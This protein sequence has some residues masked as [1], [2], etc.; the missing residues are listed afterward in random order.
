LINVKK[1]SSVKTV[2]KEDVKFINGKDRKCQIKK[3]Q[4]KSHTTNNDL[5]IT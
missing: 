2:F 4:S 5:I 3:F 1:T